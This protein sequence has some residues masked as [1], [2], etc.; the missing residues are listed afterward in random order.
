ML[1]LFQPLTCYMCLQG[2]K[3][4]NLFFLDLSYPNLMGG[5]E[6]NPKYVYSMLS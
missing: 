6:T 2:G 4:I 1:L 5:D 3:D